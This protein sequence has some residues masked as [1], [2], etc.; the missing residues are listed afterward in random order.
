MDQQNN[1]HQIDVSL[2]EPEITQF[3][4][5]SGNGDENGSSLTT[6]TV[7]RQIR[8]EYRAPSGETF[9]SYA[10]V[11]GE[12]VQGEQ[13]PKPS[14][15]PSGVFLSTRE[16]FFREEAQRFSDLE[17]VGRQTE[18]ITTLQI[19]EPRLDRLAI[20]LLGGIPIMH[21]DI[22]MG[23][24][25][26]ILVMGEGMTR[27]LSI[28]LAI[29]TT[30][31]GI[32]LIDEIE[33][34]LHYSVMTKVWAAIAQAARDADVQLFA[35]THSWE[36]ITAAHEAFSQSEDY[37]FRLYRLERADSDIQPVR[38]DQGMLDAAIKVGMEVR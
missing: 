10:R 24:L 17:A 34:G 25:L 26:P 35:T 30:S 27:L 1:V 6:D 13:Y 19:L 3:S 22:G 29:A 9:H 21:G 37:D 8:I 36:C 2:V 31:G 12:N 18:I 7:P 4:S 32:V 33:N 15:L 11:I 16:R 38:Y 14:R 23:R 5:V 28:V 20:L